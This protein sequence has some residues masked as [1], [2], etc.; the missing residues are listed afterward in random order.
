MA[1]SD[2]TAPLIS[3]IV[4]SYNS[5]RY[6]EETLRSIESSQFSEVE[7]IFVDGGSTDGTMN[8]VKK[9]QH[10]FSH[11]ISEKDK[12]QSDAFN[13]GFRLAAGDYL[14][15]L[16]SDDVF[17]QG[18]L[19]KVIKI[20]KK[21]RRPWYAANMFHI[22]RDSKILKSCQSGPFE[23]WALK[24]GVLN[25]FGPSTI[26][27]RD[28]YQEFGNFREDFHF[29]MDTEYWWR[30]ASSGKRYERIPVHLWALRL[31]EDAKTAASITGGADQKPSGMVAENNRYASMYFPLTSEKSRKRGRLLA[32]FWRTLTGPYLKS[33][34]FSALYKGR[35]IWS[36]Y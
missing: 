8:F 21:S 9:S 22:D 25:V 27:S 23:S 13:K 3:V 28:L 36:I 33:L 19:S 26:F 18:A 12:G 14:T 7:Y 30:L 5:E 35:S 32:R 17:C 11:I 2:D 15:W 20:I 6:I 29:C 4:P 10:V 16:N 34:Y 1:L 24:Y 31:H